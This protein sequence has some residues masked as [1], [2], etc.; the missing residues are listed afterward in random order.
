MPDA[1][2]KALDAMLDETL[3][4]SQEFGRI[5]DE[6]ETRGRRKR[7][8]TPFKMN[9]LQTLFLFE[10]LTFGAIPGHRPHKRRALADLERQGLASQLDGGSW[11]ITRHG[12]VA[13][14]AYQDHDGSLRAAENAVADLRK[15]E[16]IF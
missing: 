5:A 10:P 16:Q 9:I 3:R 2:T 13:V 11:A 15:S 14:N 6:L 1:T 12:V 8:L 7:S 4:A